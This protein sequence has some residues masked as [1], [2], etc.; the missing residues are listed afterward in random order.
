V[1]TLSN[2]GNYED[3]SIKDCRLTL[4]GIMEV[5]QPELEQILQGKIAELNIGQ[6]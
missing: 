6:D 2:L 3:V 1:V 5:S 4:S